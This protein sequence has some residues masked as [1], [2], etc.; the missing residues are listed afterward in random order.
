MQREKYNN[1]KHQH[2]TIKRTQKAFFFTLTHYNVRRDHGRKRPQSVAGKG[3]SHTS[4][5]KN[6]TIKNT[7]T[8][9]LISL[10][11][12]SFSLLHTVT[13]VTTMEGKDLSLLREKGTNTPAKIK[14]QQLKN[15]QRIIK[16]TNSPLQ[17]EIHNRKLK[18]Y[19]HNKDQLTSAE[20]NKQQKIDNILT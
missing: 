17:R 12:H 4:K 18:T 13:L 7:N 11:M 19:S 5:E 20:G 16:H 3:P 10:K 9:Q 15:K 1:E 14:I 8:E 2:R 6:T